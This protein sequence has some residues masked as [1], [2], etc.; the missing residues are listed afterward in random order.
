MNPDVEF[1]KKVAKLKVKKYCI[2]YN[3]DLSNLLKGHVKDKDLIHKIRLEL[4]EE[5]KNIQYYDISQLPD[6]PIECYMM[7]RRER[8]Y[9]D[10]EEDK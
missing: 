10:F 3:I 4:E 2:K 9:E 5:M 6:K 1:I 8:K 7:K